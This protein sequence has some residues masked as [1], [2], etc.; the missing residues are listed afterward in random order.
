VKTGMKATAARDLII[1]RIAPRAETE[2][3]TVVV[4]AFQRGA[5]THRNVH[6]EPNFGQAEEG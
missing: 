1:G 3:G 2:L 6:I 5:Y 4:T